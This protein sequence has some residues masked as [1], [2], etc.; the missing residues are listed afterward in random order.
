M[1]SNGSNNKFSNRTNKIK[2]K[3]SKFEEKFKALVS[4]DKSE[5]EAKRSWSVVESAFVSKL[6]ILKSDL[7][8]LEI[9]EEDVKDTLEKAKVN[10]GKVITDRTVYLQNLIGC[11]NQLSDIENKITELKETIKFLEETHEELK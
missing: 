5:M 3:M 11:K 8:G 6:A 10:A 9:E 4:E 7:I 1:Y 2:N